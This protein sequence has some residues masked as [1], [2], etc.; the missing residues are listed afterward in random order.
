MALVLVTAIAAHLEASLASLIASLAVLSAGFNRSSNFD[1]LDPSLAPM[2]LPVC[3]V[4]NQTKAAQMAGLYFMSSLTNLSIAMWTCMVSQIHQ[5]MYLMRA[6][7]T[8][9]SMCLQRIV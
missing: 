8:V 4:R 2:L 9:K 6:L 3:L 5:T 1:S 7:L